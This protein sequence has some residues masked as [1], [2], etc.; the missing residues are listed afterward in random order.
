L[1]SPKSNR[2]ILVFYVLELPMI[3]FR[4]LAIAALLLGATAA[5]AKLPV[6]NMTVELRVLT[7]ASPAGMVQGGSVVRT[8][9]PQDREMEIQK[10]YVQNGERA[11]LKLIASQPMQWVKTAVQQSGSSSSA[12]GDTSATKGQGVENAVSWLDAGQG[13]FVKVSWPGGKQ[14][15]VV[16]VEV[17]TAAVDARAGQN[18]PS[19]TRSRIA[20]TVVAPLG[21]WSTIAVTGGRTALEQPGVYSTRALESDGAKLVQVRVLAP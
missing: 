18:L 4:V 11:Q 17:E 1:H 19:Q 21:E 8:Y 3:D 5:S 13:I 16:E 6:R 2:R 14:A 9:S 7:E 15:A 20:T 10:V 12:A